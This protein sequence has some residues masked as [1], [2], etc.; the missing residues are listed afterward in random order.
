MASTD[1]LFGQ[2]ANPPGGP[3]EIVFGDDDGLPPGSVELRAAGRITG[4]RG[5]VA[6]RSVVRARAA[7]RITGL[8]GHVRV[9]YDVNV[10]R[11]VVGFSRDGWQQAR[12]L[13]A[14]TQSRVEQG[15][16]VRASTAVL[17]Q[18][19]QRLSVGLQ[20]R[21]EQAA[22]IGRVVSTGWQEATRLGAAPELQRFEDAGRVRSV[23]LQRIEQGR[24]L[25]SATAQRLEQA[26]RL[27][28]GVQDSFQDA[29]RIASPVLSGFRHAQHL[30]RVWAQR[31]EEAR[32]PPP[33][34]TPWPEPPNPEP[35]Y[36]PELPADLVFDLPVD[37]SLP[38]ELV[39][40]C[41]RHQG[42]GPEPGEPQFVIPLLKVYMTVH[43]IS[44]VR[45]PDLEPV[46][47]DS[48]NMEA[49]D[50]GFGWSFSG[51]GPEHLLEQLAPVA[52]LPPRIRITVD[53]IDWVFA[54]ERLGRTRSFGKHRVSLQGRSVTALLGEPYLPQQTWLNTLPLTAQQ[55][56]AQALEFTGVGVDWQIP[57]WLV[58]A[59]A[60]SF[61]GAPLAA[62]LRVAESVGA[63]VRSHRTAE[64]LIVAPR[65]AS[66]PWE[67]RAAA[68]NVQMPA[69][70]ITTDDLQPEPRPAYNAV[71]VSGLTQGVLGHVR[72]IG[73]A[74][75]LLAPQVS[76]SL[77]THAD[78]ARQRGRAILGAGGQ[79]L[80][81][82]MTLPL[83]TGGTNPGLIQ[84]GYLIE[85]QDIG[86][87]WRGLVRSISVSAG[88]P[89]VRQTITVERNA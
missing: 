39:F 8:R 60:W 81:Q 15:A 21:W 6:V 59:G 45:L 23:V 38:T 86:H 5:F 67:W 20:I 18:D 87:Q 13:H 2:A 4:L 62:A 50:D 1:L 10:E 53:G 47:L 80:M 22:R 3:V 35:C 11:P 17:W 58:P 77:I 46:Q 56:V 76:D 31:Y 74:G 34:V 37:A 12:G 73:S 41:E 44:A 28:N 71:Y 83:L 70:I 36:L 66:M 33:G 19:G 68:V 16:T 30:S 14:G 27:R 63:V 64:R 52:G 78:A 75:D 9:P 43:S 32:K 69:A 26:V 84:P 89:V 57:D 48:G 51:S 54:I 25:S 85:V 72:R 61:Q 55:I 29:Q 79:K 65:Y 88:M 40:V 42:P 7:G 49:D 82:T 24:R